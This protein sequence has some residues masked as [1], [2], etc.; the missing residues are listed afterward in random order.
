[1]NGSETV[2][3]PL[4]SSLGGVLIGLAAGLLLLVAGRVAGISGILGGVFLGRGDRAWRLAFLAGLLVGGAALL[5]LAPQSFSV[6]PTTSKA[7]L[8]AAGLLVGV[9][10]QL[11]SGCTSGH[12]ICGLPRLSVRSLVAVVTFIA[13]GALTVF[14]VRVLGGVS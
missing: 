2:F 4:A 8:V 10:T 6:S 12:G 14:A 7:V 5:A 11:G 13:T 9:G 3:T 1:M